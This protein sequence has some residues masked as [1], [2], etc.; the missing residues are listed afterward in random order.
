[1]DKKT[2]RNSNFELLRIL[3][4]IM[5]VAHHFAVHSALD[6]STMSYANNLWIS[7]LRNGGKLGVNIFIM[8]SGYFLISSKKYKSSNILKLYLKMLIYG[9]ILF[10]VYRFGFCKE[11]YQDFCYILLHHSTTHL[12]GF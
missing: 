3:A 11:L 12:G 5:I 8:I 6:V 2:V 1:M 7:F 9:L 10:L 4:M